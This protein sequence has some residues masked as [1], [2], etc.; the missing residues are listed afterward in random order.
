MVQNAMLVQG[1]FGGVSFANMVRNREPARHGNQNDAF[2]R[3]GGIRWPSFCN[4]DRSVEP[5]GK[6]AVR[7]PSEVCSAELRGIP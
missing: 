4:G 6:S 2:H 3:K 1:G 5:A 7:D